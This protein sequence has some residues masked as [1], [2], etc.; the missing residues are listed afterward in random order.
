MTGVYE[1]DEA[2]I[3]KDEERAS[4]LFERAFKLGV[5]HLAI[6][7]EYDINHHYKEAMEWRL[8]EKNSEQARKVFSTRAS[9]CRRVSRQP[10]ERGSH[11]GEA[12]L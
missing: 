11:R 3:P 10:K 12:S 1:G 9:S 2:V 8:K 6:A 7:R 5:S 4:L